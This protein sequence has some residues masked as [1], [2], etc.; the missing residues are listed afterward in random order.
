MF[1][2]LKMV[3]EKELLDLRDDHYIT[4]AINFYSYYLQTGPE[5]MQNYSYFLIPLFP[6]SPTYTPPTQ[7]QPL[8][9]PFTI[10][11]SPMAAPDPSIQQQPITIP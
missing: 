3:T 11:A 6:Y 9:F 2:S 10:T 7:Q 4:H 8:A 1:S 5:D